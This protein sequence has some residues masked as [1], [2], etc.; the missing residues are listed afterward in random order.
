M[1]RFGLFVVDKDVGDDGI[2][3]G[4]GVGGKEGPEV[5]ASD[6]EF[7]RKVESVESEKFVSLDSLIGT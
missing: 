5:G 7:V 1:T 4:F 2:G 6:G 3:D